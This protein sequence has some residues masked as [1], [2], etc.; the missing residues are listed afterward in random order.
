MPD[1]ACGAVVASGA[2]GYGSPAGSGNPGGIIMTRLR[3]AFASLGVLAAVF[4]AAPR[5]AFSPAAPPAAPPPR[6]RAG[7]LAGLGG[8]SEKGGDGR[9]HGWTPVTILSPMP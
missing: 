6:F 1:P 7:V 2:F 4:V 5:P 3:L 8:F 9:G